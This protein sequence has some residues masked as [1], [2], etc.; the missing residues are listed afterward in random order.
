MIDPFQDNTCPLGSTTT[1]LLASRLVSGVKPQQ[2]QLGKCW[3]CSGTSYHQRCYRT[4]YQK[5]L[6]QQAW[7]RDLRVLGQGQLLAWGHPP[8]LRAL[9]NCASMLL[10]W[11]P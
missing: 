2:T 10:G 8:V 7:E 9:G 11:P 5:R 6:E 4:S 1:S 3:A